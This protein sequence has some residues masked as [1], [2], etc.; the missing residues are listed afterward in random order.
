MWEAGQEREWEVGTSWEG[1]KGEGGGERLT[2]M[3]FFCS[4]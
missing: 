1:R 2:S 4:S 3:I